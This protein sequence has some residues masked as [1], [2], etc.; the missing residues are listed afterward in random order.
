MFAVQSFVD[1]AIPDEGKGIIP[2]RGRGSDRARALL[3]M[4][5]IGAHSC[6]D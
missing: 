5:A 1:V 4:Y 3:A 2:L 6:L